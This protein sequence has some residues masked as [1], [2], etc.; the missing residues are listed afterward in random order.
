MSFRDYKAHE[1]NLKER[2]YNAV[3]LTVEPI[4]QVD[5]YY[6]DG[7]ASASICKIV[8]SRGQTVYVPQLIYNVN[9]TDK[10]VI[11]QW[12][13]YVKAGLNSPNVL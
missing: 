13:E 1:Q 10:V 5:L 3:P 8:F 6:T 7:D 12:I 9:E 11:S 2:Y 4:E